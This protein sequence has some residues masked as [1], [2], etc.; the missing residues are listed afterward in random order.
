MERDWHYGEDCG[1]RG[2][3][4]VMKKVLVL[5]TTDSMIW[6]FLVPHIKKMQENQVEVECACSRTGSYFDELTEKQGLILHEI[7]FE[8]SPYSK[9]NFI[10]YKK[11]LRLM[12]ENHYDTIFCHEPVGG[13]MGRLVG[14]RTKCK[15]IYM[16]HGFHFYKGAPVINWLIY[17][18][19]EKLLAH[20]T[21]LL[22]TINKEDY[23]AAKKFKAKRVALINGIGIDINK[24]KKIETEYLREKYKLSK[25]DFILLTVG[26][27]IPRKNHATI[28]KAIAEMKNSRV[29]LFIAG[30]GEL[31]KE[32]KTLVEK[33]G[34]EDKIHFLGFCRNVN[35]LCNSC[36]AFIFPSVH[37]GL[38]VALME[39]MACGKPV[40]VSKI[41]GNVDLIEHKKGGFLVETN[42]VQ[43]YEKAIEVLMKNKK[44]CEK[45]G[46]YNREKIAK[47]DV[48]Y[49]EKQLEKLFTEC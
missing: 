39:A 9:K 4:E 25:N 10:A 7:P 22:I 19:V 48:K 6:N 11:L 42:D 28:I 27:L 43:G 37:E 12:K 40:I 49:V 13:A 18:H 30:E 14:H 38:S 2:E 17:Y 47:Y 34:M 16:A 26:E 41:R 3:V 21:D 23:L 31:E 5:C 29:H 36:D 8:R 20:Y 35:E 33:E 32:L 1:G 46:S 24:F 15:V 44:L 45:F